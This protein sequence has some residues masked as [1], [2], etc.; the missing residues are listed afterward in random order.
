MTEKHTMKEL[1]TMTQDRLGRLG[2]MGARAHA[3]MTAS[4]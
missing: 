2:S 3:R 1:E 4:R